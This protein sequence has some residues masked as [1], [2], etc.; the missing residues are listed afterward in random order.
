MLKRKY[1]MHMLLKEKGK[2]FLETSAYLYI[3]CLRY[4]LGKDKAQNRR[5]Y[6]D[7]PEQTTVLLHDGHSVKADKVLPRTWKAVGLWF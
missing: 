4:A 5:G 7:E 6:I 3:R 2:P 1:H